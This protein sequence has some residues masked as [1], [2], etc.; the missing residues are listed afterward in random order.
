MAQHRPVRRRLAATLLAGVMVAVGLTAFVPGAAPAAAAPRASAAI[1]GSQF[2]AGNIISDALFYDGRAMTSTEIQTFL[3]AKIGRCTNGK[4]LNVANVTIASQP[5]YVSDA[6]GRTAC[7]AVTG[8]TMRVAAWIYRVQTACGISA[9]VILATLQKE[10]GLTT[11]RAPSDYSLRFAMG[12]DCPDSTGCS[13]AAGGLASQIYRGTRQLKIYKT[14]NYQRQPGYHTIQ[15]SPTASCGGKQIRIQNYATAALYNYTPYQPNAAALANL[16]GTGDSCSSYGN[17]NFWY[18]YTSW[19]GSTQAAAP[20]YIDSGAGVFSV[21]TDGTLYHYGVSR[22]AWKPRSTLGSG[23]AGLVQV[24]GGGDF[25]GDGHRDL[26]AID[27]AKVLWLYPSDG[28]SALG[29]RVQ[30]AAAWNYTSTT[31]VGD[32]NRDGRPDLLVRDAAGALSLVRSD[33]RGGLRAPTPV[34]AGWNIYNQIVGP[35]DFDGD[36]KVDVIARDASGKLWFYRGTGTGTVL[37]RKQV[38]SGW[39]GFNLI[40]AAGDFNG[41]RKNDLM[42]R[43]AAGVL[44]VYKGTGTGTLMSGVKV[45]TGWQGMTSFSGVGMG[46]GAPYTVQSGVGDLNADGRRDVLAHETSTGTLWLYRGKA[47]NSWAGRIAIPVDWSTTKFA[48]GIGDFDGDD[49]PDVLVVDTAGAVTRYP[50]NKA[51]GF[52]AP[53]PVTTGWNI[54]NAVVNAGDFTGDRVPDILARDAGGKLWLLAGD[55]AGAFKPA[56]QA[57]IGWSTFTIVPVGDWDGDGA[58]DVMAIAADGKLWLYPGNGEGGWYTKVQ[59]GNGW[60]VFDEVFGPGDW[61]GDGR[62]DVMAR[63]TEGRLWLYPGNGVGGFNGRTQIGSGWQIFDLLV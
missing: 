14:S 46:A 13:T 25:D 49:I 5:A 40:T 15:Y 29:A 61:T 19:F 17:R 18:Y 38:G 9:K 48:Q 60:T 8:G 30:L 16:G 34:G 1:S 28:I 63:D 12:M 55:G 44:Y 11:N 21:S 54:Y 22:G 39:S 7:V 27:S 23:A 52:G 35:G 37:S 33:G 45:G 6:T 32:M 2:N 41:D 47:G 36:G 57:G 43:T 10:Q 56:V 53:V 62:P 50:G 26:L 4:C 24:I 42:A 3:D 58:G 20:G 51:G 59:L 31:A